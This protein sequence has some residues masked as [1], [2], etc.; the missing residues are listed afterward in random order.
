MLAPV[1]IPSYIDS[2]RAHGLKRSNVSQSLSSAELFHSCSPV[3]IHHYVYRLT[4]TLRTSLPRVFYSPSL[5]SY[6]LTTL[7]TLSPHLS[8]RVRSRRRGRRPL[9]HICS[10][11]R[12]VRSRRA[13]VYYTQLITLHS[14]LPHLR[15]NYACTPPNPARPGSKRK[16][17]VVSQ[18]CHTAS[19]VKCGRAHLNYARTP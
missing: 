2:P 19:C 8:Q 4:V 18:W 1:H 6:H 16:T 10:P 11:L 9:S 7:V 5:V 15:N 17:P 14:H 12:C 13:S 3:T